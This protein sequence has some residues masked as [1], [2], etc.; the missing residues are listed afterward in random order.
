MP[1]GNH[2]QRALGIRIRGNEQKKKR[3]EVHEGLNADLVLVVALKS[4]VY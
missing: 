3:E 4:D 1:Q 2:F